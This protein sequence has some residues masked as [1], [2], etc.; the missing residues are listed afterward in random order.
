MQLFAKI[1]T[2]TVTASDQ[3]DRMLHTHTHTHTFSHLSMGAAPTCATNCPHVHLSRPRLAGAA[4]LL[5]PSPSVALVGKICP[6]FLVVAG[7]TSLRDVSF[8]A[9]TR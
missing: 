6:E 4:T 1:A 7:N 5:T 3:L 9:F 8:V 2:I